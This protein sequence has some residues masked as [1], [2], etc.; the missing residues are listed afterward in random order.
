MKSAPLVIL[1]EAFAFIDPKN[2]DKLQ[3]LM[4]VITAGK[5]VI[6]IAHK[7][8]TIVNAG[9]IVVMDKGTIHGLGTHEEL[10]NSDTIYTA[11]WNARKSASQWKI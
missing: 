8:K 4:E 2:E 3:K 6:M 5:T 10:L 9:Q 11:F 7:M 1:G